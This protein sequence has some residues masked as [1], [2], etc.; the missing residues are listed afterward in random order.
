MATDTLP[1]NNKSTSFDLSKAIKLRL[2]NKLSYGEIAKQMDVPKPTVYSNISSFLEKIE[3]AGDKAV[4]DEIEPL[5]CRAIKMR[6]YSHMIDEDTVVKASA[7][8][9]AYALDKINTIQRLS[10][11]QSTTNLAIRSVSQDLN[12]LLAQLQSSQVG[13]NQDNQPIT[14]P[15]N[16][17][18]VPPITPDYVKSDISSDNK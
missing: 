11:G 13:D 2:I 16:N 18:P 15:D 17:D 5:V 6:Y 3:I 1:V 8:N 7:N 12:D 4:F 14:T 9:A 10:E